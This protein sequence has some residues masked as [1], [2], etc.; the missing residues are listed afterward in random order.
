[1]ADK[2]DYFS[3][4]EE[5]KETPTGADYF[6]QFREVEEEGPKSWNPLGDPEAFRNQ[7]E[8]FTARTGIAGANKGFANI[9]GFG[10]HLRKMNEGAER[11]SQIDPEATR[12]GELGAQFASTLPFLAAGGMAAGALAP[13][14]GLA[15]QTML[16]GGLGSAGYGYARPPEEGET[17]A[18]NAASE[19]TIGA[20]LPVG[21]GAAGK[22]A[23][24]GVKGLGKVLGSRSKPLM[25]S[26]SKQGVE[27]E[28]KFKGLYDKFF[29]DS[30]T[31]ASN[32]PV[33]RVATQKAYN[34]ES[35]LV[36]A[37]KGSGKGSRETL[38]DYRLKPTF[39]SAHRA[40]S[41]L[42]GVIRDYDRKAASAVLSKGGKG[43]S[44]AGIQSLNSADKKTYNNTLKV[45]EQIESKMKKGLSD[46]KKPGVGVSTWKE[47][48]NLSKRFAEE[49]VPFRHPAITAYEQGTKYTKDG[50][51]KKGLEQLRAD[52]NFLTS[53]GSKVD[54]L[55]ANRWLEKLK[56]G[57]KAAIAGAAAVGG[58]SGPGIYKSLF[59][60]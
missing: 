26:I 29:K 37:P 35:E 11:A 38:K 53:V 25:E 24:A 46:S 4:F 12:Y 16:S 47:Y 59:G 9:F 1:M 30:G 41:D 32:V 55:G 15:G 10:E 56:P 39:E 33:S 19:G 14:L 6:E 27:A 28:K 42:K 36:K 44:R 21:I 60:D 3:Q 54:G 52:Q 58:T 51:A 22:L 17:R 48:K 57:Q 43:K 13:G 50:L 5:V 40:V 45:I 8:D 2:E 31:G 7:V 23:G 49:A 18:G 20:M 34:L